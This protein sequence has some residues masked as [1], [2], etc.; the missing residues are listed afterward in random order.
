MKQPPDRRRGAQCG[1]A[2]SDQRSERVAGVETRL[3][4][5]EHR[6]A[7][8]PRREDAA[9]RVFGP[10]R[11]TDVPVQVVRLQADPVHGREMADRIALMRVLHEFGFRG[12]SR[13][14]VEQ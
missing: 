14:E 4:V 2:E 7:G 1:D 5:R 12:G 8:I 6:R 11:R 3:V 13:S 9:P 10:S